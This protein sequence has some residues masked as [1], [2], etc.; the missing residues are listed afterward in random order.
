MKWQTQQISTV[1]NG[2]AFSPPPMESYEPCVW[3]FHPPWF[4]HSWSSR[5]LKS[6]DSPFV[7]FRIYRPIKK[8]R[9]AACLSLRWKFPIVVPMSRWKAWPGIPSPN[10]KTQMLHGTGI[11]MFPKIG[12]KPTKWM[13]YNGKPYYNGWFGGTIIFGNTHIFQAISPWMGRHFSPFM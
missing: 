8:H 5:C 12:A 6:V 9:C 3:S 11:W 7:S 1:W 13:V 4:N 2:K 10:L